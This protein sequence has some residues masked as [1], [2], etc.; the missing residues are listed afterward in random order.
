MK[1][2]KVEINL[3][4]QIVLINACKSTAD[5]QNAKKQKIS[6]PEFEKLWIDAKYYQITSS[7]I[8]GAL[9]ARCGIISNSYKYV[10]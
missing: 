7:S 6:C 8:S 3:S 2:S 9:Q 1:G 5:I 4:K 10:F